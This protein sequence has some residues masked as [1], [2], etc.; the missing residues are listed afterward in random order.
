MNLT[1]QTT[2]LSDDARYEL[3]RVAT[4]AE[5]RNRPMF[6]LFLAGL[7]LVVTAVGAL[8][9]Y[10]SKA[11]A[12]RELARQVTLSE[13]ITSDVRELERL[14]GQAEAEGLGDGSDV[15]GGVGEGGGVLGRLQAAAKRAG[16]SGQLRIPRE[17][18]RQEGDATFVEYTYQA[19][20][21]E[22]GPLLKWLDL[23]RRE[24]QGLE[25]RMIELKPRGDKWTLTVRF[26][27]WESR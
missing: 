2:R 7:V 21:D 16:V 9:G 11:R 23:A 10:G 13:R 20:Q 14:R 25:V 27:R 22:I 12:E 4:I 3:A 26:S 1:D 19:V 8:L 18:S 5:R 17:T 6:L 15:A 24:I